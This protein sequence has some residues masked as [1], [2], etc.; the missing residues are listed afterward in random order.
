VRSYDDE[1]VQTADPS[2]PPTRRR[3]DTVHLVAWTLLALTAVAFLAGSWNRIGAVFG[4]SDDGINGA[5]WATGSRGLREL[6]PI[7][8]AMGGRHLD[9]SAYATHPPMIVAQAAAA[10]TIAGERPWATRAGAWVG[11][12]VALG[13]LYRLGRRVGF[14]PVPAAAGVAVAG[15]TG[16][17]L[18]YG[19]M[20]D[21][22][23]IAF[24]FAVGTL[25]VWARDWSGKD[26]P[27][28][29][30]AGGVT[31][32]ACLASWQA[33]LMAGVAGVAL[34][35]RHLG[36]AGDAE[37]RWRR[38]LPYL[39]G[40]A[41][42]VGVSVGWSW[43]THG[44]LEVLTAKL[45]RRSGGEAGIGDV[46][47]FQLA[48]WAELLGLG[49]VGVIGAVAA[50]W[51]RR[52]RGVAAVSLVSVVGYALV[53][54]EAAAGHQYWC[55]WVLIP[56][57]IGVG[58]LADRLTTDLA[59]HGRSTTTATALIAVAALVMAGAGLARPSKAAGWIDDATAVVSLTQAAIPADA[60]V[61]RYVGE[62]GRPDPW[63]SYHLGRRAVLVGSA[64]QLEELAAREPATAVL[65]LG[66][67]G[68]GEASSAFCRTITG[69]GAR[70]AR[71]ETA[72][73][74]A[75]RG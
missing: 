14:A 64:G 2:P 66:T 43:W 70:R 35:G 10:E 48:W 17:A 8:S 24:P 16:M 38:G 5:V 47:A 59:D 65:V 40:V 71:V 18:T 15:T 57:A 6:G 63:I 11:T 55:Y 36:H 21:T 53:F 61:V 39:A 3:P 56:V 49:L 23:V 37:G 51:D 27:P 33:A 12:L 50:L 42:G 1:R 72:A 58:W 4:D 41:I 30:L 20:I 54:R 31:T 67:C 60:G 73:T 45:G 29:W 7:E 19:P 69:E 28:P 68:E 9:G 44:S 34:I 75:G 46:V 32:L 62:E 26:P 74:L 13:L 52:A 25:V 22:P